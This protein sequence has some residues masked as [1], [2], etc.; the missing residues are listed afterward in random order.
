MG[1]SVTKGRA[2]PRAIY[3]SLLCD[4]TISSWFGVMKAISPKTCINISAE[5]EKKHHYDEKG[6]PTAT[7]AL[8]E[9]A[10]R[11]VGALKVTLSRRKP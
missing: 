11:D 4:L 9:T 2:I 6:E 8:L 3:C 7:P 5:K 10:N 1:R